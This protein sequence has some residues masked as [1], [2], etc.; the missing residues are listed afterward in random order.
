MTLFVEF[1]Q[2]NLDEYVKK[3]PWKI[4]SEKPYGIGDENTNWDIIY[5]EK[6]CTRYTFPPF[7]PYPTYFRPNTLE[8][9]DFMHSWLFE[10]VLEWKIRN[11][12]ISDIFS[13]R[14]DAFES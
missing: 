7:T 14:S 3:F 5:S 2:E 9:I 13:D 6:M 12:P 8:H 4:V 1:S 10:S 11:G